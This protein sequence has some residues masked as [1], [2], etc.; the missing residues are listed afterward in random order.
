MAYEAYC[1][2]CT[3]LGESSDYNGKYWC[4]RK[5]K[6]YY[7]CDAKCYDFCE[8]YSRSNYAR[9]NMYENSKSH[10]SSGGCYLTSIVC[11]ILGYEDN[12]KYLNTL[13]AFRNNVLQKDEKYK[14]LLLAYDIVGP[15]ISRELEKD[16]D[17]KQIANAIMA[18]YIGTSVA[19]INK[20]DYEK[21]VRI[22]EAMTNE[23]AQ[24]YQIR[25][26][27]FRERD[28]DIK[29]DANKLGHGNTITLKKKLEA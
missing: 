24:R 21:A 13:R 20:G 11:K 28:F 26:F 4:S 10:M 3:Y 27:I 29:V 22:Y 25:K 16:K 17:G 9:E 5:G 23:L 18:N 12:N 14:P 8:A 2:A 1:A 6:D 7:A 19:A 15:T